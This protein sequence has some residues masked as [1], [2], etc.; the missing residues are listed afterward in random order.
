LRSLNINTE[1]CKGCLYCTEACPRGALIVS[2]VVNKK[3]YTVVAV[4]REKCVLCGL[5]YKVCP[6]YAIEIVEEIN[7]G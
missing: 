4:D 3:G 7:Y 6:D 2:D 5:C 1:R